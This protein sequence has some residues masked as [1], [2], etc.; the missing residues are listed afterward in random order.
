MR[1][2]F[3]VFHLKQNAYFKVPRYVCFDNEIA[4]IVCYLGSFI[5]VINKAEEE[6]TVD[7]Y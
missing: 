2:P 5:A 6:K 4:I 1:E 7:I 3:K